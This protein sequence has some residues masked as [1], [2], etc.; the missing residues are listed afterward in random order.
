MFTLSP[1]T[2]F[3]SFT[4]ITYSLK[5][6]YLLWLLLLEPELLLH[7][8]VTEK[9]VQERQHRGGLRE[10]LSTLALTSQWLNITWG[11]KVKAD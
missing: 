7:L 6:T 10:N 2:L 11:K 1:G 8:I 9:L 5:K 3:Q 4:E